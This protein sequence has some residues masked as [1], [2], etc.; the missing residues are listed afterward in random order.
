M[1]QWD[2]EVK[3]SLLRLTLTHW[4]S[5][6]S[7]RQ[8]SLLRCRVAPSLQCLLIDCSH[9]FILMT[10]LLRS[11][12][13]EHSFTCS[14]IVSHVTCAPLMRA[15]YLV[16]H[17]L[18][19]G[20]NDSCTYLFWNLKVSTVTLPSEESFSSEPVCF[21]CLWCKSD[22]Q[23]AAPCC[24]AAGAARRWRCFFTYIHW[25]LCRFLLTGGSGPNGFTSTCLI[26]TVDGFYGSLERKWK[27][28]QN[29]DR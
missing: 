6:T 14:Y 25:N 10:R 1:L 9:S 28:K 7:P 26:T 12:G 19:S 20:S 5:H 11:R 16:M 22:A 18:H 15:F 17:E 4:L 21:V 24:T 3:P 8:L 29:V 27:Q 13:I 23:A 2:I